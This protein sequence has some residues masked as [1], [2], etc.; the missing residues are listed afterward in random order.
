MLTQAA[1]HPGHHKVLLAHLFA[2]ASGRLPERSDSEISPV[3]GLDDVDVS[4]LRR[5]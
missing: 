2:T 3:G 5:L 4:V 1:Y